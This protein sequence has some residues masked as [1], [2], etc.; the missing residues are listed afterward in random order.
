PAYAGAYPAH[1]H[2]DLL[3][4][5]QGRGV[6]R[7]LMD[8]FLGALRVRG[9]PGVHLGVSTA[10]PGAIAFYERLGFA[11]LETHPDWRAYG[12]RL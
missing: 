6:G 2:I 12:K 11:C 8:A 3:P 1:L 10:N 4:V 5:L 9:V 7:R